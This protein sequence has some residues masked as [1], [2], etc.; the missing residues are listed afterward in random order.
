M[1]LCRDSARE[2]L[3]PSSI[4]LYLSAVHYM[5]VVLGFP[6]PRA[7]SSLP[8]LKLVL[9]GITRERASNGKAQVKPRLPITTNVLWKVCEALSPY[10]DVFMGRT[11]SK[12]CPVSAYLAYIAIRGSAPG[13]FFCFENGS[14]L[15][16]PQFIS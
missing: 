9:N 7:E 8:R 4:K 13:P 2:G 16:K 12:L 6:E 11:T 14:P 5:Q 15:S 10:L 1:L 3:V